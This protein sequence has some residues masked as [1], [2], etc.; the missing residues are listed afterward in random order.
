LRVTTEPT[1]AEKRSS[2]RLLDREAGYKMQQAVR[3]RSKNATSGPTVPELIGMRA[4]GNG[5]FS[6][7]DSGPSQ[8]ACG[9]E[10]MATAEEQAYYSSGI[11]LK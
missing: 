10:E 1:S 4:R 9:A 3:K 7:D 11:H 5:Y 8:G 2:Q 6:G